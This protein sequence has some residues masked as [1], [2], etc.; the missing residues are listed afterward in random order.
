KIDAASAVPII[1]L[2]VV[3]GPGRAS[4]SELLPFHATEDRI[5]LGVADM[6]GVMAL[7]E[8]RLVC[9]E[10]GERVV[11]AHRREMAVRLVG[12]QAGDLREP[13]RRLG[14]AVSRNDGVIKDDRHGPRS[15]QFFLRM[16]K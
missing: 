15:S 5:E 9:E 3:G 6:K 13:A 10:Q 4:K 12:M 2:A 11:H 16:L 1:E 7:V 8:R 14:F